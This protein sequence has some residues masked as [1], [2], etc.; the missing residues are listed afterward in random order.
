MRFQRINREAPANGESTIRID[1]TRSINGAASRSEQ[2]ADEDKH[3]AFVERRLAGRC[4]LL[5]ALAS[6]TH[7]SSL[8][9][10]IFTNQ[11]T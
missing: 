8:L 6:T 10:R 9:T 4:L 1:L 11:S 3:R 2:R 7:Q 5:T